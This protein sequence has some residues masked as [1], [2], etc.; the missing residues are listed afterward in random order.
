MP[1]GR[2]AIGPEKT[3]LLDKGAGRSRGN[4]KSVAAIR[5]KATDAATA[6]TATTF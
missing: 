4:Q 1:N 3:T 2:I 5:S 6:A